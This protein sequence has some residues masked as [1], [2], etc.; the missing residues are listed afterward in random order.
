VTQND[1][2]D[3]AIPLDKNLLIHIFL[4]IYITFS[5]PTHS[6]AHINQ[7]RIIVE[8]VCFYMT[9]WAIF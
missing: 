3:P 8:V 5:L 1:T 6:V 4:L 2:S 7:D 9:N